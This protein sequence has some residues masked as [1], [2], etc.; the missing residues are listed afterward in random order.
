VRQSE[1]DLEILLYIKAKATKD[2]IGTR[3]LVFLITLCL[4]T[5]FRTCRLIKDEC[6]MFTSKEALEIEPRGGKI[7]DEASCHFESC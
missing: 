4:M 1:W 3:N 7:T 6:V 5:L 2:N